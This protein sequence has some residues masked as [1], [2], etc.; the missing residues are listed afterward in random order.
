MIEVQTLEIDGYDRDVFE[1]IYR[2]DKTLHAHK[3]RLGRL[4][5]HPFALLLDL[6]AVLFK[7]NL[8]IRPRQEVQ[9][10]VLINRH[11]VEAVLGRPGI[12]ALRERTQLNEYETRIVLVVLVDRLL[13]ALTR[14][15]HMSP[16]MLDEGI[17]LS[18]EEQKLTETQGMLDHLENHQFPVD[19]A[20]RKQLAHNLKKEIQHQKTKLREGKEQQQQHADNLPI[21]LDNEVG[22]SVERMATELDEFDEHLRGLGLANNGTLHPDAARRRLELGEKLARS[23]KLQLLAR[24]AG[25]LKEIAFEQRKKSISRASQT[26]HSVAV[27]ADLTHL[28]PSELPG[29][30]KQRRGIHLDFLRRF[31]EKQLMQY[32]LRAPAQRG[33]MVVCVDGSSS[34]AGS[35]E[36]WA[37]AVGLT[38]MEIARRERRACLAIVFSD[39]Q[40]LFEVELVSDRTKFGHRSQV[41]DR[42]VLK[43]AEYFPGGGTNFEPPLRRALT[44][45]T[46]RNYRRGDIIFITDGQAHLDDA[47]VKEISDKKKRHRF[48]IRS[49]LVDLDSQQASHLR[50]VADDVIHIHDLSENA[51]SGIFTAV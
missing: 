41:E 20:T 35:K 31:T 4:L 46:S 45:V 26:V 47:L 5:P 42:S 14:S 48:K 16:S 49:I 23:K 29:L 30:N 32:D 10:S 13:R 37:K 34:M 40:E 8:M 19:N 11:L 28:L 50:R 7:L 25:T 27:G 38:L 2:A 33:P 18:L 15:N 24:L 21:E 9:P 44:A 1:R 6:F 3:E 22:A 17:E 36:V 39:G 51:L 12:Q 43:F